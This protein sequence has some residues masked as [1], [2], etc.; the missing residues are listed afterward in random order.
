MAVSA[1]LFMSEAFRVLKE[2]ETRG[3]HLRILGSLAYRLHCPK[4]VHILDNMNR[5]L[6]DID[7]VGRSDER[8]LY[9]PFFKEMGFE[10]DND[11][12]VA[13][14]GQ[15]FFFKSPTTGLG[16]DI[17]VDRLDFCHPIQL[18]ERIP[19]DSPTI[20]LV[21]LL[22]E[23]MQIVEINE[24]DLKDTFVLLLEHQFG[25]GDREKI[26]LDYLIRILA[27]D[28]GFYYTFTTN[29][30]KCRAFLPRYDALS[31]SQ[32]EEIRSKIDSA[33]KLIEEAP[34]SLRWKLR[35]K[36]GTRILWYRE[37]NAKETVF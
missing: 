11:L 10:V 1:D 28:W 26:D 35:A 25:P 9:K 32:R 2:A 37:V 17:F 6:T 20:P 30:H 3:I 33:L 13:T 36:V 18:K 15:R 23:K 24:K 16:V 19:L 8:H 4:Y 21:D 27:A 31:D 22:M 5:E 14:E 7:Y 34:K 12:L 29:L